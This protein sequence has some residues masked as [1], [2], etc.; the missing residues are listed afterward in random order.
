M[1]AAREKELRAHILDLEQ[2]KNAKIAELE[3]TER[4]VREAAASLTNLQERIKDLSGKLVA[5]EEAA[6]RIRTLQK[7]LFDLKEE[8]TA[9]RKELSDL[10]IR[11][12]RKAD[13]LSA[14]E[15]RIGTTKQ[16]LKELMASAETSRQTVETL[17]GRVNTLQ[18]DLVRLEERKRYF[19]EDN[20][21]LNAEYTAK[22]AE[23]RDYGKRLAQSYADLLVYESR[24]KR[25]YAILFPDI[26]F[27]SPLPQPLELPK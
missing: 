13:E 8:E 25:E 7:Q 11:T 16:Q 27:K 19:E 12:L 15:G 22:M 2:T 10:E 1:D 6:H 5:D 21:K 4:Q 26:P 9:K 3:V 23:M 20:A 17:A 14:L 24:L 18:G